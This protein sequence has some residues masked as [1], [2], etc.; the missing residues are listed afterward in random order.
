M[1]KQVMLLFCLFIFFS[2]IPLFAEADTGT[3]FIEPPAPEKKDFPQWAKDLRRF[4]IIMFG[5]FP[6]AYFLASELVDF[7]RWSNNN[8]DTRYAPW[9]MKS[10]G[11][12]AMTKED[13]TLAIG[14]AAGISV[15]V[16]IVDYCVVQYKQTKLRRELAEL[17]PG[18]AIIRRSP[19]PQEQAPPEAEDGQDESGARE[20]APTGVE[21]AV[22]EEAGVP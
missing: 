16:A 10:S 13:Y 14:A 6:F 3:V 21:T 19:W 20:G 12:V 1:K 11:A 2:D 17:P 18:E 9:P 5:A 4:E 15:F 8:W 7:S 22:P